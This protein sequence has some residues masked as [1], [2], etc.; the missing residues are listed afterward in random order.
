LDLLIV[1]KHL[2]NCNCLFKAADHIHVGVRTSTFVQ[3]IWERVHEKE[4]PLLLLPIYKTYLLD[5]DLKNV[6]KRKLPI[7]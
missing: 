2:Y 7:S 4:Q 6:S 1:I 5:K 3:Y